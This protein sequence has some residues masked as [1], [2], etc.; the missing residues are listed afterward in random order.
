MA[1]LLSVRAVRESRER[2]A[3][4]RQSAALANQMKNEFVSM[5]SHELRTP[6]TSIAGFADTLR[7]SWRTLPGDEVDEFLRII[8]AQA[9]HLGELVEDVLVIPRIEA[10]RLQLDMVEFDLSEVVREVTDVLFPTGSGREAAV[11]VGRNARPHADRKRVQQIL[12][13]L[14]ENARKY[15]G[16]QILVEAT[17]VGNLLMVVVSDNGPGV[18]P[19]DKERIFEHF[20]QL[21]KGDARREDG[22]GLGLPIARRLARSMGGDLW[23]EDR[24]PTGSRFCFTLTTARDA[25]E[26]GLTTLPHS[27]SQSES[28]AS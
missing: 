12:R 9:H 27:V 18:P 7:A 17:P 13:N 25:E 22:I 16:D 26:P 23:Y 14:C 10:G 24:F 19:S 28:Q 4:A 3:A 8:T 6:L 2:E 15:G 20:E 1:V 21:T 11:A 5:V